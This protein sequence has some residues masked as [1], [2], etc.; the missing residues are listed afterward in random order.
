MSE[1]WIIY[2]KCETEDFD[3]I[4]IG[5]VLTESDADRECKLHNRFLDHKL[6]YYDEWIYKKIDKI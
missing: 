2:K 3:P 5:Y 6:G 4:I 1:I